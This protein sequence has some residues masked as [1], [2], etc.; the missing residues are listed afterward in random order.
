[1][2]RD[3]TTTRHSTVNVPTEHRDRSSVRSLKLAGYATLTITKAD[4]PIKSKARLTQRRILSLL[5]QH[6][7]DLDRYTVRRLALFG[8]YAGGKPTGASD[9]D[10]VVELADP[11]L[12][13]FLNLASYLETLLG[14]RVDL[15]TPVGVDTIRTPAVAESIKSALVDV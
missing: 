1:M 5:R 3:F 8:S 6:Q 11:T 7:R 13:N 10:F 4:M 15:L 9:I 12:D 14:R 2:V